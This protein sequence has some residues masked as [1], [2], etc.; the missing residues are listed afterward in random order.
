MDTSDESA[1]EAKRPAGSDDASAAARMSA[2]DLRALMQRRI[3]S[4]QAHTLPDLLRAVIRGNSGDSLMQQP[5]EA[6]VDSSERVV[7]AVREVIKRLHDSSLADRSATDCINVL[8]DEVRSA[9][10]LFVFA[11]FSPTLHVRCPS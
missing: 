2:K 9:L 1:L 8:Q 5:K 3:D 4:Q 11:A 7:G 10:P 6:A